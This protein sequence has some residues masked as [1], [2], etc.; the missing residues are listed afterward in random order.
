M[1][2]PGPVIIFY[3]W[4]IARTGHSAAALVIEIDATTREPKKLYYVG[5]R[6]HL[7]TH[8]QDLKQDSVRTG[9]QARK[10]KSTVIRLTLKTITIFEL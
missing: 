9:G 8:E 10:T 6:H 4:Y 2:R 7:G 3:A 5:V 1:I